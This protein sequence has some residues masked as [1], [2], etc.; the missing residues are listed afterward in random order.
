[1]PEYIVDWHITDVNERVTTHLDNVVIP[2]FLEQL[3]KTNEAVP[4]HEL[5][6]HAKESLTAFS[7]TESPKNPGTWNVILGT[8][9]ASALSYE[10]NTYFTIE[11]WD[12]AP[13]REYPNGRTV[14]VLSGFKSSD[15]MEMAKSQTGLIEVVV[16]KGVKPGEVI[17]VQLE[18]GRKGMFEVPKGALPG[19]KFLVDPSVP[20]AFA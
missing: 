12:R 16:P 5:A 13:N 17:Q 4:K 7:T 8:R 6:K 9:F 2:H 3:T 18:D 1:M 14:L 10:D 15:L 20:G 19:T 11:I